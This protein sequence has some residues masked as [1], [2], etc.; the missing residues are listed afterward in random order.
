MQRNSRAWALLGLGIL[1]ACSSEAR[2]ST[3][4]DAGGHDGAPPSTRR[5]SAVAAGGLHSLGIQSDG[6]LW[7]WGYAVFGQIGK[8]CASAAQCGEP[9]P[10]PVHIGTRTDWR[11]VTGGE[12]HSV[13]LAADGTVW[14]WG[15]TGD[16]EIGRAC[17]DY[18]CKSVPGM[19]GQDRD[20]AAISAAGT[21]T[22]AL[23]TDGSLWTWGSKN[24]CPANCGANPDN[25][26]QVP[27]RVDAASD[28]ALVAAGGQHVL[29]IKRD[30]SRWAWGRN[31]AGQLGNGKRDP[32]F[33]S[34]GTAVPE[35]VGTDTDWVA[36]AAGATH[37]VALKADGTLW[38][39]G[40]YD[41]LNSAS[42]QFQLTPTRLGAERDW[43]I[44][45]A[46]S[47]FGL[48]IKADGSLWAWGNPFAGALGNGCDTCDGAPQMVPSRIGID[49]D[50]V[51]ISGDRT[52]AF[53][54]LGGHALG[55]RAVTAS[56]RAAWVW[57]LNQQ[58]QLGMGAQPP[59][60][61]LPRSL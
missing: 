36:A 33:F 52:E 20:W 29:A 22:F 15:G 57:G 45:A 26:N 32:D 21:S 55:L 27:A 49:S 46:G 53:G 40:T 56:D 48:A 50:W 13:A 43:K 47:R 34:P 44:L 42:L 5:W 38:Y 3:Q 25:Y 17:A 51:A 28:W 41:F 60:A 30:G 54:N 8:P 9:E 39:W 18:A 7:A 10:L 2:P 24:T 59:F 4:G 35:R 1:M 6:S 23:K 58:D 37:S 14:T 31:F 16:G 11:A 61:S 12:G 19:V